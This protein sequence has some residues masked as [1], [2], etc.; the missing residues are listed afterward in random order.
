MSILISSAGIN[1]AVVRSLHFSPLDIPH[2]L[3]Y[4]I[5]NI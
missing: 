2:H 4:T 5:Y 1:N 3:C